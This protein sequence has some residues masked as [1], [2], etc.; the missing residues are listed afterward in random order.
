MDMQTEDFLEELTDKPIEIDAE[1]Q[2]QAFMDRP[3]SPLF[4]PA[5]T[6]QDVV[7]QILPGDLFDFDLEV[8]PILEVLVGKTLHV[9][10]LELMQEEELEVIFKFHSSNKG[11]QCMKFYTQTYSDLFFH[12]FLNLLI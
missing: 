6:G 9:S 10:M 3:A 4:V 5:R 7:T 2:T 1:T 8:E 12:V 11:N